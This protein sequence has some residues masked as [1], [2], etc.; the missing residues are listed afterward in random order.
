MVK[1]L[2]KI[3]G[4]AVAKTKGILFADPRLLYEKER[5][6]LNEPFFFEGSS[7]KAVILIHGWTS[8]PYELRRLG[9]FLNEHGYT[10]SGIMLRGHGTVP[11]D[12]ENIGWGD[13]LADVE[14]EYVRL[15]SRYEKVY[16]AGTSIGA[17]LA[18]LLAKK[19]RDIAGLVVMAT[20]YQMKMEKI[21]L[22]F[23][24]L[25]LKLKKRYR[26]KLYPPTFGLATTITRLISYQQ[27]PV[28]S[29]MEAFK[30]VSEARK[31]LERVTQ[32]ILVMQSTHDHIVAK[33]SLEKIYSQ[34]GST[35]KK[36][37][38]IR[39]AYHT[40]I[41]DIKNE[42]VFTDILEFLNQH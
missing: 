13:W 24:K 26:R 10:A 4:R 31:H 6:L 3:A 28:K 41:S 38:Y 20:P 22:V 2:V 15:K 36:K 14:S 9:K 23:A 30:I 27:Y 34:V 42:H 21:V 7:N 12:L 11:A 35:V 5:H 37:K 19:E 32:P 16:I 40:F 17:N 39:K 18:L 1:R 25:L 29:V 33:N 8:T